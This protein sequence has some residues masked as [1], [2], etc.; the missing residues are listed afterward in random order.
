MIQT[1]LLML[2]ALIF[3]GCTTIT[4]PITR[5][6]L[7]SYNSKT[8]PSSVQTSYS[9]KLSGMKAPYSLS[10]KSLVYVKDSQE[11]GTYLYS[12]WSDT[13]NSMI[14]HYMAISL[15]ESQLFSSLIPKSSTLQSDLLLESSLSSF[16]HRIHEDK[17]SDGYLDI[18][19]LL[20]DQK[21]KK[22]IAK[23]RFIITAS[24][25]SLDAQ[26]GVIALNEATHQ[27]ASQSIAW[28]NTI[29]KE[30]KWTK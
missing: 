2:L 23:K 20:I 12:Q 19:Y 11:I 29:V 21:T 27:L 26:G 1:T 6:T 9:L 30:N 24:A 18:T 25:P 13:P 8:V 17:S 28:L 10:T 14:E 7:L 5:Y 4:P 3:A 16:Y 15:D 22:M